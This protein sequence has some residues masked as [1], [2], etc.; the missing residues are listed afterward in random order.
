MVTWIQ[1]EYPTSSGIVYCFSQKE[2]EQV[3]EALIR[4]NI[5]A[6]YY[7]V[8]DSKWQE[9]CCNNEPFTSHLGFPIG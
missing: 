5:P 7:H 9:E 4:H 3:A 1:N 2:T 6:G 8:S